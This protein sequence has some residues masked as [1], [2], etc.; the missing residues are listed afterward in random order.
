MKTKCHFALLAVLFAGIILGG[1]SQPPSDP[2]QAADEFFLKIGE[3]RFQDAYESSTFAFQS[4][5]PLKNFQVTAKELGL[6]V[7]GLKCHWGSRIAQER[8]LKL[9]G[10]VISGT[11]APVAVKV[12]LIKERGTWR[13]FAWH[14]PGDREKAETDRFS[15]VGNG[16]SFPKAALEK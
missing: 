5:T 14:T 11:G 12:T 1:C 4:Q 16:P 8:D 13:V 2:V 10:E 3:G 7:R 15:V 9:T 6:T